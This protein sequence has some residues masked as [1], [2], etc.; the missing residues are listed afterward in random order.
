MADFRQIDQARK[1][2]GLGEEAGIEEIKEAY[3]DLSLKYHPDRCKDQDKKEQD[4]KKRD[5]KKEDKGG[6]TGDE[7]EKSRKKEEQ[8]KKE[9]ARRQAD[10]LLELMKEKEKEAGNRDIMNS[11]FTGE[12]KEK[13]KFSGKDW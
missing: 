5:Q 4:Q 3:R 2:L 1:L 12:A 10:K 7:Q 6:E 8:R 9:A 13:N 11:R